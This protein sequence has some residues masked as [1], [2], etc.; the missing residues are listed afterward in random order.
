MVS[1]QKLRI[2]K[3]I[4]CI[5][6]LLL[7]FAIPVQ[8]QA[9]VQ[10]VQ[11]VSGLKQTNATPSSITMEW[12]PVTGASGYEI[13]QNVNGEYV[14][15]KTTEQTMLTI[16]NLTAG[17]KYLYCVRPFVRSVNG[18]VVYGKSAQISVV[19]KTDKPI[20]SNVKQ[21]KTSISFQFTKVEGATGYQVQLKDNGTYVTRDMLEADAPLKYT[22]KYLLPNHKYTFRINAYKLCGD[23]Y[24]ALVSSNEVTAKTK[25]DKT[26]TEDPDIELTASA[27]QMDVG[28][29][30]TLK[31]KMRGMKQKEDFVW[32]F[33]V[34][35][36][37]GPLYTA[38]FYGKNNSIC[39]FTALDNCEATIEAKYGNHD[40][41][42]SRICVEAGTYVEDSIADSK[43]VED[44]AKQ[45][46]LERTTSS[47]TDEEKVRAIYDYFC[48]TIKYDYDTVHL[49]KITRTSYT[50]YG[51]LV[52]HYA[53]CAGYAYA[54]RSCMEQIGIECLYVS[55]TTNQQDHAWNVVKLDG[56]WYWLDSTW[57]ATHN[58]GYTSPSDIEL[59]YGR[60]MWYLSND[61]QFTTHRPQNSKWHATGQKYLNYPFAIAENRVKNRNANIKQ[62]AN[63]KTG[64]SIDYVYLA[65]D[66][67]KVKNLHNLAS[68]LMDQINLMYGESV[69]TDWVIFND[70]SYVTKAVVLRATKL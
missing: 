34:S 11:R 32:T 45:L 42:S 15:Q 52:K 35:G 9:E 46:V 29:T 69:Y 4:L 8:A 58:D 14:T 19:T 5:C 3:S 17:N 59:D 28:E 62:I 41:Y 33:N 2:T 39:K 55:G 31:A 22:M 6:F 23:G 25:V 61:K 1:R 40:V 24:I 13:Q 64:E 49:T 10:R 27:T 26:E 70:G 43:F 51:A 38:K 47:M 57:G 16:D 53:V 60:Y 63:L 54:F 44:I 48:D 36:I 56:R 20:I 37:S 30:I 65:S 66:Y 21:T 7:L 68:N 12:K 18:T 50:A 67:P